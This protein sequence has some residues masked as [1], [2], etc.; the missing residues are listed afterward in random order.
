MRD[1]GAFKKLIWW[2]NTVPSDGYK[3]SITHWGNLPEENMQWFE[4]HLQWDSWMPHDEVDREYY[5]D[6]TLRRYRVLEKYKD[7]TME[8]DRPLIGI[9]FSLHGSI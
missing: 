8:D 9:L 5:P 1:Y 7:K 3:P 6:C 4:V 2:V